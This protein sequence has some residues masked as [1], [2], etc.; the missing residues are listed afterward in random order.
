MAQQPPPAAAHG[1]SPTCRTKLKP[2]IT[3]EFTW[4]IEGLSLERMKVTA[5][6]RCADTL[7][8]AR[9]LYQ[10]VRTCVR[11]GA[12]A[13]RRRRR[14]RD[15]LCADTLHL[16]AALS[17]FVSL[18]SGVPCRLAPGGTDAADGRCGDVRVTFLQRRRRGG[19]D[20]GPR[21]LGAL[22]ADG[23][24]AR[25][26]APSH[27]ARAAPLRPAAAAAALLGVM[28]WRARAFPSA[29][30]RGALGWPHGPRAGLALSRALPHERAQHLSGF[31]CAFYA[32]RASAEQR[33]TRACTPAR[34]AHSR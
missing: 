5:A 11:G 17:R 26:A 10:R 27:S 2:L 18:A 15:S 6:T 14:L 20:E 4:A 33:P 3:Q 21:L 16:F 30:L 22:R 28:P 25:P 8:A 19:G 24:R 7:D 31:E 34:A 12:A 29:L 13:M 9:A 1:L 32:R 23:P